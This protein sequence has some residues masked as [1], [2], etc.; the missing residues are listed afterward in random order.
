MLHYHEMPEGLLQFLENVCAFCGIELPADPTEAVADAQG[1]ESPVA[2]GGVAP[3]D[4]V[5]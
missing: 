1:V 5:I 3:A 4:N 2:P